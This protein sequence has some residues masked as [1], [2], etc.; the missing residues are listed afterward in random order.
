[1]TLIPVRITYVTGLT[2]PIAPRA[3]LTGSWDAAGR[4]AETWSETEMRAER[5]AAG[6]QIFTAIVHLDESRVG[7]TFSWGVR[8]VGSDG[9]TRWAIAAEPDDARSGD[10]VRTFVLARA[11]GAPGQQPEQQETYHLT[12][13]RRLGANKVLREGAAPGV[14][15]AVWAPNATNVELVFGDRAS[16]YIYDD[17]R[18]VTAVCAMQRGNDGVWSTDGAIDGRT[19]TFS[20]VDHQPYMFRIHKDDGTIAYRT[21]LYSR[22]QIGSGKS[23]PA[24]EPWSGSRDDLSG[25]KSCSVVI[26]PERV[27][28]DFLERD[29]H[30]RPAWPETNWLDDADFWS[31]ELDPSRPLPKRLEDAVI[32]ELHIDGLGVGRDPADRGRLQDAIELLPHLRDLGV[33]CVELLPFSEYEGWVNWGYATS[34][35]LALEYAG[36]GR[37]QFKHFV[38]E[39]HRHGIAVLMDVVYNHF[40]HDAERA[41]WMYDSNL[42]TRNV[43]YWY[44]GRPSDYPAFDAVVRADP[45]RRGEI[46]FGGYLDNMS[47]GYAP[48]FSEDMVRKLFISSAAA[49]VAEFHVDGF[50]VDQTTSIHAY[51]VR[52]ADGLAADAARVSGAK[53]LREWTRTMRLIKPDVLLVAEDHSGWSQVTR[54]TDDGGLGFDTVWYAEYYHHLIGDAQND[55]AKA[56]LLAAAGFGDDRELKMS[57]FAGALANAASGRVIYHE[58]H[59]EA[60]NSYYEEDGR[61]VHSART[62]EVAV[63]G[64]P[65]IGETRRWAEARTRVVAGITLLA[66]GTPMMFMG[67]EVG[68]WEPY[69]YDDFLA[70]RQDFAALRRDVGGGLFRFYQDVIRLRLT[71]PA[72]RSR[73]ITLIHTHDARRVLAF[74]RSD[75]ADPMLIVASLNNADFPSYRLEHPAIPRGRWRAVLQSD[76]EAY[77][78]RGRISFTESW[79]EGGSLSVPLPAASVVVLSHQTTE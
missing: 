11:D 44:E 43:Y 8:L 76:A 12:H 67:E 55:P 68:A 25:S 23:D 53:F 39:C 34:H 17:G 4:L 21:D 50:R 66:P 58:S 40:A 41:E 51:P 3:L 29:A 47:T 54:P 24:R 63:N 33:N 26:D 79:A 62:I 78:G 42:H 5:G 74:L 9:T 16:G 18:G 30:G 2:T 70:H 57:W 52:H 61:R 32:Y 14:R 49:L 27:V 56:R 64:A 46:G 1:M 71:R 48:R 65:L 13:L 59:D 37:D 35:Y 77:G 75:G 60:G 7:R 45:Q 72:L 19:A 15:F 69:R 10:R 73:D 22:C 31:D 38:R 6:E 20:D 28:R 36:G